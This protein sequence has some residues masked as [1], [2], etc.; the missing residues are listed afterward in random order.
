[1]VMLGALS[2]VCLQTCC[3]VTMQVRRRSW[4]AHKGGARE[5]GHATAAAIC[6]ST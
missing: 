2:D 6:V 1:M 5:S 4:E 3:M